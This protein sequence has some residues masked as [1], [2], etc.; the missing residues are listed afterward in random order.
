M[1]HR[2]EFA[3]I[4]CMLLCLKLLASTEDWTSRYLSTLLT[5]VSI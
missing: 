1:H 4:L 2:C 3:G 5:L